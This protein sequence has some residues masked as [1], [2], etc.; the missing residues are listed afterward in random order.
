MYKSIYFILLFPLLLAC[1]QGIKKASTALD[2]TVE[3]RID[4]ILSKMTLEEKVG[5]MGQYTVDVIGKGGNLYAS[6]EPFEIDLAMLDTII[7]RYKVGSILNTSNNRAR[8]PEVWEYTVKTI[9]ERALRE[10]GIPVVYGI[11]AI[12]GVTY[13]AGATFFPQQIGMGATFNPALMEQGSRISA[14]ETRASNIPWNFAP[15]LDLG[16]DARWPRQWETFGEDPFLVKQM[17]LASIR[18]F[19]GDNPNAIGNEHVAACLKHFMG[20]GVPASGK[21]RTPAVI[22]ESELRE[23]HFEPFRAA[24]EAGVLSVMV[25]SGIVNNVSTHADHR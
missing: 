16:R 7:G 20:Y 2:K 21:D 23:K 4:S 14:Y 15:I 8:T 3:N 9:Q 12:H 5:Q 24:V 13:T 25:N 11:D 1:N 6:D 19:Q 22:T 18:G 17:G 10:T